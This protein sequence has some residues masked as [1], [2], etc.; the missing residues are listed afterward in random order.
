VAQEIEGVLRHLYNG[1]KLS[2]APSA[3]EESTLRRWRNEFSRK[4]Q[5]WAGL[6]E[7]M[8]F[9]LSH[10]APSFIKLLSHPLRR[11]EK[12]LS[13]LPALPF[14]WTVLIKTLWWLNHP[15]HF[16]LGDRKDSV[17]TGVKS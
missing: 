17:Y 3:A 11:L 16:D 7:S 12:A 1:S 15:T 14:Q 8:V 9:K 6:L 5:E 2:E 4:M 13:R 10:R